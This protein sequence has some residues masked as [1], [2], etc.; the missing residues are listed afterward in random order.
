MKQLLTALR[1]WWP[2][3]LAARPQLAAPSAVPAGRGS[4]LLPCVALTSLADAATMPRPALYLLVFNTNAGLAG[5]QGF[6][7]N[8]GAVAAPAWRKL[9]FGAA[10]A[11]GSVGATHRLG[12]LYGLSSL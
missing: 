4:A 10:P 7:Y 3:G 6:Y 5:G 1:N 8:A 11:S 2:A 12:G 9:T